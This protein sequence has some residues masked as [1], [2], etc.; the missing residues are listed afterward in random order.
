MTPGTSSYLLWI[1]R[2]KVYWLGCSKM[3]KGTLSGN[4]QIFRW[5]TLTLKILKKFVVIIRKYPKSLLVITSV[6]FLNF[7]NFFCAW[8]N[9]KAEKHVSEVR[10]WPLLL[11]KFTEVYIL[12]INKHEFFENF[13]RKCVPTKNLRNSRQGDAVTGDDVPMT[14]TPYQKF[15]R[16]F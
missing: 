9:I 11:K 13:Q 1:V 3:I 14:S 10:K 8:K 2:Y 16:F 12:T 6:N 4:S 7:W 5:H 15:Q